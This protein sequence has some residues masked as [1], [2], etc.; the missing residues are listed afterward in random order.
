MR[1]LYC[2]ESSQSKKNQKNTDKS[3]VEEDEVFSQ[4]IPNNLKDLKSQDLAKY[5]AKNKK[6]EREV[7]F[8]FE[9]FNEGKISLQQDAVVRERKKLTREIKSTI[10][11]EKVSNEEDPL[12]VLE[13]YITEDKPKLDKAIKDFNVSVNSLSGRKRMKESKPEKSLHRRLG[14][15][16]DEE[17]EKILKGELAIQSYNGLNKS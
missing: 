7:M 4:Y 10:P 3:S 16:M 6:L 15:E 11:S 8:L 12:E 13:K 17:L 2:K 5:N 1:E 14:E 9:E